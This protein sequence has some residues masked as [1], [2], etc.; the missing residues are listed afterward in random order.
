MITLTLA[1]LM[2]RLNLHHRWRSER[3]ADGDTYI[4]CSRCGKE[5]YDG[6]PPNIG[7]SIA[8]LGGSGMGGDR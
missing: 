1:R 6:G 4:E 5:P 7:G 3:N 2:C 8:G